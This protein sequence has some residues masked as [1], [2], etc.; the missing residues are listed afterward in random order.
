M[1]HNPTPGT[2]ERNGP[3][4]MTAHGE[5]QQDLTTV[6]RVSEEKR[7][8]YMGVETGFGDIANVEHRRC[9]LA[10][11]SRSSDND[12]S[13]SQATKVLGTLDVGRSIP[14]YHPS[15]SRRLPVVPLAAGQTLSDAASVRIS[16][17]AAPGEEKRAHR[18]QARWP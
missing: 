12:E 17:P 3:K 10:G 11:S 16:H 4:S 14:S 1:F 8:L 15:A 2:L 13:E 18:A 7:W 9:R 6:I 5:Q